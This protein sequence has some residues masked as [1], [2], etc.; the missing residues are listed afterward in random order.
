MKYYL[1]N[2]KRYLI[3]MYHLIKGGDSISRLI[4]QYNKL[5]EDE[6]QIFNEKPIIEPSDSNVGIFSILNN[7]WGEYKLKK[8][9]KYSQSIFKSHTTIGWRYLTPNKNRGVIGYPELFIGKSPFGG[10]TT[11]EYFPKKI[12]D[13]QTLVAT[14]DVSMYVEPKKYNLAFDLWVTKNGKNETSDISHEI[15]VWEDRNVA[16]PAGKFIK[17][18]STSSG[19]YRMYHTYMDRSKE[20]F[21]TPGWYF[22]AFVRKEGT[23]S[24]TVNLKEFIYIMLLENILDE[25]HF[26][27]TVEF[28]NEIYNA[29]GYTIV[30]N[31]NLEIK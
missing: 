4:K 23:R 10:D 18:V 17:E 20:N 19:T 12:D 3:Y 25:K 11:N 22:T 30:N 8:N 16:M 6:K 21:G 29:C 14:Y 28:G 2:A 1:E 7:K 13:I 5:N 27:S 31:Y 9:E 24:N 15:M 26:I